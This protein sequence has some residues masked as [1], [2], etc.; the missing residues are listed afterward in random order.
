[1]NFFAGS[2]AVEARERYWYFGTFRLDTHTRELRNGDAISLALT[3][4]VFDTLCL[5]I[6]NRDRIVSREELLAVVWAGRVVEENNL[7]Q[8]IAALRRALGTG[9]NDR[10]YIVTTPGQGYRFV[11]ELSESADGGASSGP[12]ARPGQGAA[13]P[14]PQITL[15]VLPFR[16]LSQGPRDE[17]LELGLAETLISRLARSPALRVRVLESRVGTTVEDVLAVGARLGAA[18]VVAG[19]T[20]RVDDQVRVSV[21]LLRVDGGDTLWADVIDSRIDR[22]FTLQDR[23]VGAL[24]RV[25]AIQPI[26]LPKRTRNAGSGEDPAVYRAWLQGYHL[27]QRPS[28]SNLERAVQSFLH[29]L[30]LG[31]L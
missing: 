2:S 13:L 11:A 4:K 26:V 23:I 30:D 28:Q 16:S 31:K 12:T 22:V 5:L 3:G 14:V 7:A 21:Q 29:A 19:S 25:L 17:L 24:T 8:A 18:Y 15:A 10:R 6:R 9:V 20:Q 1:M 27:A